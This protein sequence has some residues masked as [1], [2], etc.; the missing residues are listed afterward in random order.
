MSRLFIRFLFLGQLKNNATLQN[1]HTP[2]PRQ[3][4]KVHNCER[5]TEYRKRLSQANINMI[6]KA[7]R[8]V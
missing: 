2:L 6:Q 1:D 8:H 7:F 3:Q 5:K 4:Q